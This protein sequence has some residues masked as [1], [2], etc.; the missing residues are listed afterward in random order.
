MLSRGP[1]IYL[2]LL[3]ISAIVNVYLLLAEPAV[4]ATKAQ[5]AHVKYGWP[6]KWLEQDLSRY[7]PR[8]FPVV[9]EFNW[10]RAWDDPIVTN[11]DWAM[12]I[13]GVLVIGVGVTAVY[14]VLV[15]LLRW[16]VVRW[17]PTA[18]QP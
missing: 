5:L 1:A 14:F 13:L 6:F 2:C 11:Y 8:E 17:R 7:Q 15:S 4:V 9:I 16:G 3:P 18:R 10:T 12:M